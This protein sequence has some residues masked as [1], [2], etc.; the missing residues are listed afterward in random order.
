MRRMT[1]TLQPRKIL[2]SQLFGPKTLGLLVQE[3]TKIFVRENF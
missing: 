3:A 2:F 1:S